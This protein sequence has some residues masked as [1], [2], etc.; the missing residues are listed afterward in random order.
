MDLLLFAESE[1]RI[2]KE[3][4]INIAEELYFVQR[5]IGRCFSECKIEITNAGFLLKIL[6]DIGYSSFVQ[7]ASIL[8]LNY[9]P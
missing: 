5:E 3:E 7:T 9:Q 8:K 1:A 2:M 4:S 6:L